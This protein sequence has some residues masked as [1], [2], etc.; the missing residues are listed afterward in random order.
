ML[1][2]YQVL[3]LTDHGALICGQILGDLGANVI[4]VE[5]PGGAAAR[6]VG[7]FCGDKPDVNQSLNFW[8]LNR[9]KRSI[10]IDLESEAGRENLLQLVKTADILIESFSPGYLDRQ[11]L[12]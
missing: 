7:P 3:D 6:K 12:G 11:G 9:N 4:L 2:P 8:A 5:P 10:T 1:S